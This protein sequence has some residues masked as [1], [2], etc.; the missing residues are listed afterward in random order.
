MDSISYLRHT[1]SSSYEPAHVEPRQ[2]ICCWM[3][4]ILHMKTFRSP[5]LRLRLPDRNIHDSRYIQGPWGSKRRHQC[6]KPLG[7]LRQFSS[8][9]LSEQSSSS[10]HLHRVG[11]HRPF[12]HWNCPVSHSDSLSVP[13]LSERKSSLG[14]MMNNC[15]CQVKVTLN[16]SMWWWV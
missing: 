11:M 5:C 4:Q 8:S 13:M 12:L 16:K 3:S 2:L 14:S 10:S 1:L 15:T 6:N 9:L 7:Y